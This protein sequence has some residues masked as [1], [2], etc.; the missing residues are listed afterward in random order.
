MLPPQDSMTAA[1]KSTERRLPIWL[2]YSRSFALFLMAVPIVAAVSQPKLM[3]GSDFL[4]TFYLAG[5]LVTLGRSG[6]LYPPL[7]ATSFLETPFNQ[8]AHQTLPALS[9]AAT[10]IYM[11]SPLTAVI[12]APFG[13]LTPEA[14]MVAWQVFSILCLL[15]SA[16]LMSHA[17]GRSALTFFFTA[18]LFLPVFHTL[19]IGH[20]GIALGILP[21]ALGYFLLSKEKFFLAG[22]AFSLLALKPQFFPIALLTAGALA[23]TR[24]F[25]CALGLAL[26]AL[27]MSLLS[28]LA[29]GP[30]IL[31]VWFASFR[32]SDTIF[33]DPRYGYPKYLVCSM[34]GALV[35]LAPMSA[36]SLAKLSTYGLGGAIGL[37]ALW[38]A[39]AQ[40]LKA[41][42]WKQALPVVFLIGCLVL[43]LVLPHFLFYDLCIMAL[44]GMIVFGHKWKALDVTLRAH[45]IAYLT[46]CNIYLIAWMFAG[47]NI[48]GPVVLVV[49][50]SVLYLR[51]MHFLKQTESVERFQ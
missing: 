33:S 26:G 36:R 17:T 5:K 22:L 19:L 51:V 42:D 20:L 18:F 44:A 1:P 14:A 6:D 4:M 27:I 11:Y 28:V 46:V 25:H 47:I 48:W 13:F 37:H 32:L 8:F 7:T 39:R 43:P 9:Q 3:Q 12:M 24:R 15:L 45:G 10:A 23:L 38:A 41:P 35:Q 21:L 34:P 50:L 30:D 16:L 49:L 31:K 40:I 29:C 2:L